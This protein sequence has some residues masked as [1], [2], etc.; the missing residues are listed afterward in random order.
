MNVVAGKK[1]YERMKGKVVTRERKDK[2]R[3]KRKIMVAFGLAARKVQPTMAGWRGVWK[4]EGAGGRARRAR[5]AIK[6][7]WKAWKGLEL[8]VIRYKGPRV[9]VWVGLQCVLLELQLWRG[10]SMARGGPLM[11]LRRALASTAKE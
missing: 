3:L 9:P 1:L 7:A 10:S 6:V 5:S 11:T 2:R 4:G 8:S